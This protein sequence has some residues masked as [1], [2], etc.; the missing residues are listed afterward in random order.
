MR[1]TLGSLLLLLL[2]V[3]PTACGDDE[4]A[5]ADDPAPTAGG[6]PTDQSSDEPT[7]EPSDEPTEGLRVVALLS[8]TA[9]GGETSTTLTPLGADTLETFLEPI[10]SAALADEVRQTVA[11]NPPADYHE[12]MGA[13]VAVGCDVPQGVTVTEGEAGYE[14]H[15]E[16]VAEPLPECFAPVTTIAVVEVPAV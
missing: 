7:D 8:E 5:T 3:V 11:D 13:V 2:L 16:K 10:T 4:P 12:L 6:S 14:I 9:A 15:A 1:R